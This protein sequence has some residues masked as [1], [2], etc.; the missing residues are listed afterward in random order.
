MKRKSSLTGRKQTEEHVRKRVEA[1]A[2]TKALWSEE[3]K[4]AWKDKISK[5]NKAG[6]PEVRQK[7]SDAHKG[8]ATG[9]KGR[10]YP[11][12]SG[13]NH[14]NF[15]KS[16]PDHVREAINKAVK[17]KKQS[18][19][20]V[21]KRV[22]PLRGVPRSEEVKQKIRESNIKTW[23][24]P[25]IR[26]KSIGSN[27]P[28]WKGG[29]VYGEG[30]TKSLLESIRERDNYTCRKC[31]KEGMVVHHIDFGKEN[32][33]ESNLETLCVSCHISIHSKGKVVSEETRQKIKIAKSNISDE[34]RK[35]ISESKKGSVVSEEH[36]RKISLS[37]REFHNKRKMADAI[38][39]T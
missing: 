27:N 12:R 2:K 33:D 30:L 21:E 9:N 16:M 7:N 39:N 14:W 35:R 32:H 18:P 13:E 37:L 34:T 3:K 20:L 28:S 23:S 17:G 29:G 11:E 19:E 8:K 22:A 31:G 1:A 5:N 36:R 24:R 10:K 38:I 26:A 6:T 15:G 4:A 25:E